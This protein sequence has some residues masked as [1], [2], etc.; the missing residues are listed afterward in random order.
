MSLLYSIALSFMAAPRA[1]CV[2]Q[3]KHD[4]N[5]KHLSILHDLEG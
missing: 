2:Y 1:L 4:A 5:R 3:P